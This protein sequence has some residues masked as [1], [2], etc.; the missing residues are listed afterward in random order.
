[1]RETESKLKVQAECLSN[2]DGE[3][4][5]ASLLPAGD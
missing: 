2:L 3:S 1:M 4:V 5:Q